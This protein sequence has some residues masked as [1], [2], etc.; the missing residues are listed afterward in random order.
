[1][2]GNGLSNA[3]FWVLGPSQDV[4]LYHSYYTK[5]GQEAAGEYRYVGPGAAGNAKLHAFYEKEQLGADGTVERTAHTSY[6]FTGGINQPLGHGFNLTG[7]SFY[8]TDI[9]TQQRYQQDVQ[10]ATN[11]KRNI[12]VE[13]RGPIRL[14]PAASHAPLMQLRGLFTRNEI[15]SGTQSSLQGYAPRISI[16][17]QGSVC[18]S[19]KQ[20]FLCKLYYQT[21]AEGAYL[22][23]RPF[24]PADSPAPQTNVGRFD[25]QT[26]L[27]A[28]LSGLSYLSVTTI[29]TWRLTQYFDSRDPL[30]GIV[31]PEPLTRNVLD[32]RAEVIGPRLE[33][34]FRTPD[35]HFAQGFQHLIEPGVTIDWLSPYDQASR[36]FVIDQVDQVPTGTTRVQYSLVNTV[37]IKPAGPASSTQNRDFLYVGIFQ[38]YYSNAQAA[39]VDPSNPIASAGTISPVQMNV[40]FYPTARVSANFTVLKNTLQWPKPGQ[41]QP[42]AQFS[43]SAVVPLDHDHLVVA[44][45]WSKTN[46]YTAAQGFI[47]LPPVHALNVSTSLNLKDWGATYAFHFDVVNQK[48]LQQHVVAYYHSQCCGFAMDYQAYSTVSSTVPI[49][50]RF[51]VTFTLAGIGSFSPPL[52]SFAR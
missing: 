9:T 30:T 48:F 45:G 3:F 7:N 4:T 42:S 17:L 20:T 16:S 13:V 8:F 22:Q 40:R 29:A 6:D 34:V 5:A 27:R 46:Y 43:G 47:D 35:S 39:S 11:Q 26:A 36:I 21:N 50:H 23:S 25:T 38:S 15:F 1:V 12:N 44:A 37:K 10:A 49:D 52:G 32:L 19:A 51:A 18:G 41:V 28:P 31:G 33:R 14:G 2:R 24:A